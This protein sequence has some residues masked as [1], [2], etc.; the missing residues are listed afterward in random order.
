[1]QAFKLKNRALAYFKIKL[2][3]YKLSGVYLFWIEA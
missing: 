1:L 3:N 2:A